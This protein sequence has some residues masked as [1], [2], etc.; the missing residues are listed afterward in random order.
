[1]SLSITIR[2]EGIAGVDRALARLTPLDSAS[3]MQGLARLIQQQT[4][5]RIEGEKT[6]PDGKAWPPNRTGTSTLYR[7]GHLS[8]SIDYVAG[9]THLE[10]GSGLIYAAIHQYG[11]TIV[12]KTKKVLSWRAGNQQVF[13][14]KVTIPA[15]PYIGVSAANG[16][17]ILE[18]TAA[19]IRRKL[20]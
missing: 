16:R 3:L 13:A 19:Y 11:G 7:Q 10:V 6:S 5:R 18:E 8:R 20:G 17:E 14:R 2:A 1:M 15:R 4:R 9:A 12:P